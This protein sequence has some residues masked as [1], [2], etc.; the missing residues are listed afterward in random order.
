MIL[1]YEE[2]EMQIFLQQNEYVHL[3]V[4]SHK[5]NALSRIYLCATKPTQLSPVGSSKLTFI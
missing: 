1:V 4:G 3:G 5:S 2:I